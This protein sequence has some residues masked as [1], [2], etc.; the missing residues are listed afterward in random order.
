MNL[1]IDITLDLVVNADPS[2]TV[3]V[4]LLTLSVLA[5]EI[6]PK[7][8]ARRRPKRDRRRRGRGE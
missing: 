8:W 5:V 1:S 2:L 7:I 3:S 6:V 4:P